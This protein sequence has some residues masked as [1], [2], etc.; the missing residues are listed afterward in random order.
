MCG[1][2]GIHID[3]ERLRSPRSEYVGNQAMTYTTHMLMCVVQGYV[4]GCDVRGGDWSHD[5]QGGHVH[6][7]GK[8]RKNGH[9]HVK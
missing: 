5:S 1:G 6:A 3:N 4:R 2:A 9:A 8:V 7:G